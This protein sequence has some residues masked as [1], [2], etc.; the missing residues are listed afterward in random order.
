[1]KWVRSSAALLI[2]A[3]LALTA[4]QREA[5]APLTP[6]PSTGGQTAPVKPRPVGGLETTGRGPEMPAQG[7]WLGAWVKPTW[8][9][10]D[11]RVSALTA[12]GEQ[13][14]GKVTLAH[15][16][17]EWEDDFPGPTE[18]AFQAA[19]M[20][21][22]ISWSGADTR[23][24]TDGVYDQLIRQ[25]A[26]K[27]KDFGVPVLLRWRW[28]MDRPNLR[29][30]V[31]SPEDY[32]AAWKHIRAIF[33]EEGATN[34][35]WVWCPHV[36]GF[37]DSSRNAAAYYPGD[38]QVDWLC[39]DVYPGKDYDGFAEQMDTFMAFARQRPRPVLIGEFGVTH[40]GGPGQRAAWLREARTYIKQHPQIKAVVYFS[41][42]Q[43]KGTTYDSTFDDDPEGLAAYRE[44][45]GDP[46]FSAPAPTATPGGPV[47]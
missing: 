14:G 37:V 30:S 22:M 32:V 27:I 2:G 41:A 15:M 17:H 21:Q 12:F 23:S 10:P 40:D 7:A 3:T 44:L 18:N 25:R 24:I 6:A 28:E 31:R 26:K 39:T 20:L 38:D 45:A 16:F 8:Q 1:M 19:Q 47:N 43:T 5:P 11:G 9:T 34:A 33:T 36:L 4:C 42:K 13:T 35:G 46:Y 29:Q